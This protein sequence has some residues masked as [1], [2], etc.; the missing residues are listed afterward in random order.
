MAPK[1]TASCPICFFLFLLPCHPH[2]ALAP[3]SFTKSL[4]KPRRA[5]ASIASSHPQPFPSRLVNRLSQYTNGFLFSHVRVPSQCTYALPALPR[6]SPVSSSCIFC[7]PCV[8]SSHGLYMFWTPKQTSSRQRFFASWPR[9]SYVPA[10]SFCSQKYPRFLLRCTTLQSS[11]SLEYTSSMPALSY[12]SQR[13]S[14]EWGWLFFRESER[15]ARL[16]PLFGYLALK[17]GSFLVVKGEG[18]FTVFFWLSRVKD[19]IQGLLF[20]FFCLREG[21]QE[22]KGRKEGFF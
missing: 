17:G 2:V 1:A 14:Q 18:F 6:A 12:K 5:F 22:R 16:I 3:T 11:H 9:T 13:E 8:T 21:V 20:I 7:P 4:L 19:R 15:E 10:C